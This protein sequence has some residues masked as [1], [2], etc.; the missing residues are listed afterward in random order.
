MKR[1][2]DHGSYCIRV[3]YGN[4]DYDYYDYYWMRLKSP[5][6]AY[7]AHMYI[8]WTSHGVRFRI[9]SHEHERSNLHFSPPGS[10]S[11]CRTNSSQSEVVTRPK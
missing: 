4:N 11:Y 1:Y 2:D 9:L 10:I 8:D 6:I 7:S 5:K 3:Q